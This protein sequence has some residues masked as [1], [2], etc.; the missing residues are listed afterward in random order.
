MKQM[1]KA[2]KKLKVKQIN[3]GP[4]KMGDQ[5]EVGKQVVRIYKKPG[6]SLITCTCYNGTKFCVEPTIC[7]H[8]LAVINFIMNKESKPK[9][10]ILDIDD[11]KKLKKFKKRYEKEMKKKHFFN[12]QMVNKIKSGGKK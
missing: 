10:I 1:I 3:K 12:M 11:P 8:K 7:K 9:I 2:A 6:R 5:Y 4:S